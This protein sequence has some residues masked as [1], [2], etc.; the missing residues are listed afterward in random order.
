M[1]NPNGIPQDWTAT[2]ALLG[3]LRELCA[4]R[5]CIAAE[6]DAE[7]ALVAQRYAGDLDALD[8]RVAGVRERIATFVEANRTEFGQPGTK[9]RFKDLAHGRVGFRLTSPRLDTLR[10]LTTDQVV[11]YMLANRERFG[12]FIRTTHELARATILASMDKDTMIE[13]GLTIKQD[14]RP[15]IDPKKG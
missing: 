5:D 8:A 15:F 6:R 3:E 13:V 12:G 9:G 7:V 4:S 2:E 1:N 11:E 14:D 10:G